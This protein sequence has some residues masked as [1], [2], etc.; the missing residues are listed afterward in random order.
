[1]TAFEVNTD[2]A[3]IDPDW[4]IF[5]QLH[6]QRYGLAISYLKQV[7]DG[8]TFDN[9][10]M[11][12]KISEKGF[13]VQSK[14]FPAA[15]YGDTGASSFSF[16]PDDEIQGIIFDAV[17]LYRSGDARSLTCIYTEGTP[18]DV[19]FGYRI[20]G[21]E[22]YHMNTLRMTLPLHLRVMVEAQEEVELL[23]ACSGAIIYQ[24]TLDGRHLLIRAP[25]RKQPFPLI[26]GFSE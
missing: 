10:V 16:I 21:D 13:Y 3:L 24:R 25:G 4:E 20:N 12:L 9:K 14:N 8:H 6:D 2:L 15:F 11:N 7:V 22:V 18:P 19:F 23:G 1:M 26:D 5:E 17:S